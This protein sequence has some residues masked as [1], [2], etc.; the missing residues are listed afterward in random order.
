MSSDSVSDLLQSCQ[1]GEKR[2]VCWLLAVEAVLSHLERGV[3]Q[4]STE[5]IPNSTPLDMSA[6]QVPPVNC[7]TPEKEE[8]SKVR[9]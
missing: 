5:H 2:W 7:L 4:Q 1:A 6:V 9:Q 3:P 8:S